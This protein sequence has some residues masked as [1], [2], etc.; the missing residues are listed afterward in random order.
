MKIRAALGALVVSGGL[1]TTT[2]A[3]ERRVEVR[4]DRPAIEARHDDRVVVRDDHRDFDHGRFDREH[5]VVVHVDD[6]NRPVL[7]CR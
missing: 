2:F 4:N 6:C 5:R 7:D 1:A 3:G